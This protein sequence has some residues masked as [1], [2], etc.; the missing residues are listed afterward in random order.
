MAFYLLFFQFKKTDILE[1][2][3]SIFLKKSYFYILVKNYKNLFYTFL[4]KKI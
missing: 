1:S 3:N 4:Y 2:H